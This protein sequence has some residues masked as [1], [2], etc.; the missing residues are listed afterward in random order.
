MTR[1]EPEDRTSPRSADGTPEVNVPLD[2]DTI[3]EPTTQGMSLHYLRGRPLLKYTLLYGVGLA[4]LS[5]VFSGVG[6]VVIPNHIQDLAFHAWFTGGDASANL[7]QLNDLKSQVAAGTVTAT[8]DQT[9]LL[10]LLSQFDAARATAAGAISAISVILVAVAQPIVG[11]LSDRTRSRFGRRTPW[12]AFGAGVGSLLMAVAPLAPSLAVLGIIW[13]TVSVLM[14]VAQGPVQT[15]VAD[16]IPDQHRGRASS[17]GGVGSFIGGIAGSILA[18]TMFGLIGLNVYWVFSILVVVCFLLFVT[19]LRDRSSQALEVPKSNWRQTLAGFVT[20]LRY[21]DFRWV[22]ISRILLMFG[23]TV[24]SSLN[25]FM[26]QSYVQPALS[27]AQATALTPVLSIAS[28]PATLLAVFLAGRLSDRIGRRKPFVFAAAIIMAVAMLAP[29]ISPSLPA[30]FVQAIL[31][32][33]A[34]GIYLPVDQALFVSVLPDLENSAGRDL[35]VAALA[36][37]VG[38]ALGPILA[39]QVVAI[40]GSYFLVWPIAFVLVGIAAVAIL[41]VRGAR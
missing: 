16:R 39:A 28:L 32:G 17:A 8:A 40:S 6:G 15:T 12:I 35:G 9:R 22:W 25:F 2:T 41:P 30:M 19:I 10:G 37:N 20:P 33:F 5:A 1:S 27:Q 24:S 23:Y 11:V 26:L 4:A 13:V 14:N 31:T 18:A 29:M 36:T 3:A 21:K 7:Q 34:F 38:Q